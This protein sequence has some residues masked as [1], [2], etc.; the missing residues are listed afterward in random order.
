[1]VS[2]PRS[3]MFSPS[4]SSPRT[5][6]VSIATK[7]LKLVNHHFCFACKFKAVFFCPPVHHVSFGIKLT[8]LVIETVSEFVSDY[9]AHSSVVE[10]IVLC[11]IKKRILHYACRENH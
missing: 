7:P 6:S 10:C 11:H 5:C 8:S 1:M 3:A 2:P 4:V 9:C